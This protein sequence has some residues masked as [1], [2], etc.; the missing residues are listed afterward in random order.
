MMGKVFIVET[1]TWLAIVGAG[2]DAPQLAGR[3]DLS[4][5]L[6]GGGWQCPVRRAVAALLR[7]A[8]N[9]RSPVLGEGTLCVNASRHVL[10]CCQ[11]PLSIT[12]EKREGVGGEMPHPGAAGESWA[13]IL[14]SSPGRPC[15]R[16]QAGARS[17]FTAKNAV[18]RTADPWH[19]F[20]FLFVFQPISVSW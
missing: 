15:R 9:P 2:G 3:W 20:P 5:D 8:K 10:P 14:P 18:L 1:L 7:Q 16:G 13:E 19:T 4:K 17:S 11:T 6:S 12:P